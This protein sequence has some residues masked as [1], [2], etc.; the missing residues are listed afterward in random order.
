[1]LSWEIPKHWTGSGLP[2]PQKV[3]A[4]EAKANN[5]ESLPSPTPKPFHIELTFC[6]QTEST[7]AIAI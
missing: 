7:F 5:L 3:V 6:S 4:L 2:L 1:M